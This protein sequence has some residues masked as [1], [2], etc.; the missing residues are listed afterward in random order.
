MS[1]VFPLLNVNMTIGNSLTVGGTEAV[2]PQGYKG[3]FA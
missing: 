3:I 1:V 2:N